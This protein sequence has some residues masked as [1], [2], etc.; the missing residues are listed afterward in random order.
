[1]GQPSNLG[2]I[3]TT[4]VLCE[5]DEDITQSKQ[6]LKHRSVKCI[7]SHRRARPEYTSFTN[8]SFT[9]KSEGTYSSLQRTFRI[10]GKR[11]LR[12]RKAERDFFKSYFI[13]SKNI[14]I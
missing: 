9:F 3:V 1:M 10:N 5:Y 2:G 7:H 6:P 13:I 4:W 11:N 8:L 14:G 12:D